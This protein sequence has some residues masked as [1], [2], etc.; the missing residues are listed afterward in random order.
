MLNF[1]M[2][3]T[4]RNSNES[5]MHLTSTREILESVIDQI[6]DGII[7]AQP[8]GKVTYHNI[9][10][11]EL[12]GLANDFPLKNLNE[13]SHINWKKRMARAALDSG[14]QYG[15]VIA[16]DRL[17]HFEEKVHVGETAR[18][19]EFTVRRLF[20]KNVQHEIRVIVVRDISVRR[21]LEATLQTGGTCGLITSS[22]EMLKLL[23]RA[24]QIA[25]SDASVL[26]QGESGTGK[27]CFARMIHDHSKRSR[28]PLVEVN[29]AAIP[30]TLMESEFFGHTK[31]AFTGAIEQR[32]GKFSAAN[33][34]TLFLDEIGE[35]PL[36]LQAKLLQA[37]ED[38]RFQK[39]GSNETTS[40][41]T[42]LI[43][44]SNVNLRDAVDKGGFRADLYY[45]ISVIPLTIPPLRDRLGD[46]PVLVKHFVDDL[47]ARGH[48]DNITITRSAWQ[49]LLNYPW[50]GNIRELSNAVEHGVICAETGTVDIDSLP[51]DIRL[52][53][54]E[55]PIQGFAE[56]QAPA[57][58]EAGKECS[59]GG[60]DE[61]LAAL[62][63]AH[64]S[65]AVAAQIL[66]IDRTTLWRRM[67][68]QGI[69]SM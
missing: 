25:A 22:P 53:S 7:L 51:L 63:K 5:M 10:A 42:R 68:K 21:R 18:F 57:E 58:G 4:S 60:R 36:H 3:A 12:F 38:G 59:N 39:I 17:I 40:V 16:S 14:D 47:V 67:Q 62:K 27:S 9:R 8:D 55:M 65:K 41:S 28:H 23:E 29:C 24:R 1:L 6:E 45:R 44:A 61:L 43:C 64:G 69:A 37:I 46:V 2:A 13:L 19:L 48:A 54:Q 20:S 26:L 15:T 33:H 34:G 11:K 52:Y 66:G 31:G 30:E 49:A 50:P 56:P 35:I 32:N